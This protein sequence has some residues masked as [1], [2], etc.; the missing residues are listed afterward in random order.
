V[1][2]GLVL[3]AAL[4]F[5]RFDPARIGWRA[6]QPAAPPAERAAPAASTA[7][8]RSATE[9][10]PSRLG[11]FRFGAVWWAELKL[12]LK[13]QPV[14]W[15]LI[16]A[17]LIVAGTL[18]GPA[19]RQIVLPLAWV[20]PILLWSPL[21]SR[22]AAHHTEQILF[23]APRAVWRQLPAAWLAG[24]ALAAIT[25]SGVLVTLLFTGDAFGLAAWFAGALFVP[26]LALCFGVLSGGGKLFEITYLL[27]WYIGP[28][29]N[30]PALDYTGSTGRSQP[31]YFLLVAALLLVVAL[32]VRRRQVQGQ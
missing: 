6:R 26:A 16:A 2:A 27:M 23:S 29:N 15:F 5:G 20:W 14:W 21:G 30:T 13:G 10:S 19:A 3:V 24:V 8:A 12:L 11:G 28:L 17:G 18:T 4:C 9:L 22:A 31:L 1:A 32:L 7:P 25:G